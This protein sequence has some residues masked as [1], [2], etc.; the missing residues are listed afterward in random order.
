M[1]VIFLA[2]SNSLGR[3]PRVVSGMAPDELVDVAVEGYQAGHGSGE[4]LLL[5][6]E[7]LELP[8]DLVLEL[9]SFGHNTS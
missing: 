8:V 2:T 5:A 9:Y 7:L 4:C 1:P 6:P 3:S